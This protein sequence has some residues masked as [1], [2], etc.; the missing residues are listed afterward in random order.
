MPSGGTLVSSN[1]F[2]LLTLFG[3][4]CVWELVCFWP[5]YTI[6][7]VKIE[8]M[9]EVYEDMT[10]NCAD[11]DYRKSTR[12]YKMMNNCECVCVYWPCVCFKLPLIL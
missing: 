1:L 10:R 2:S 8:F 7:N 3:H 5:N 4:M 6:F 12:Y 11:N 9:F